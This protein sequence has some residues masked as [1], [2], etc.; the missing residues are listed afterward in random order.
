MSGFAAVFRP[1]TN[2]LIPGTGIWALLLFMFSG[3]ESA[4]SA[5]APLVVVSEV[6]RDDVVRQVP[7][8]GTMTSPHVSALSAQVSGKVRS[9]A[10]EVGAQVTAGSVLLT[11]DDELER[12]GL[13]AS[14]A[15]TAQ[16]RAELTDAE[17]RFENGQRLRKQNSSS[18]NELELLEAEVAIKQAALQ[19][20]QAEQRRQQAVVERHW[21]KAPFEGVIS[22]RH[23]DV[24]EWIEPGNPVFTL[25]ALDQLRAEFRV[26]QEFFMQ[27]DEHSRVT[28]NLDALP[29]QAFKGHIDA[30][31]PVSD[32]NARTF[33]IHVSFDHQDV[34]VTPGM[35]VR[36][37]LYLAT[38][39]TG[40]VIPR[41]AL[42][43]YPDG[44][45]TVWT[46]SQPNGEATVSEQQVSIGN[47]F[48][49]R[50]V[51][52]E[53]L[54]AGVYVVIRGNEALLQGQTV[55]IQRP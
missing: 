21:V 52:T 6:H 28:V 55:R 47:S 22:E 7:L 16:A 33:L 2:F 14:I 27:I 24:G 54:Q 37:R 46:V 5:K 42:L 40:V 20:Q 48:D 4:F 30:V 23:A 34:P 53:G 10:V 45:I 36:G 32:P 35:S 1:A 38:G 13:Q 29:G 51:I 26:P 17:R 8:T 11:I 3:A 41:D 39:T 49:G 18:V 15:A 12:L 9:I 44:R 50:V 25:V 31:V 43:R 19:R